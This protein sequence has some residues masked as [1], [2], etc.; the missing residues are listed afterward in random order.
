MNKCIYSFCEADNPVY[1]SDENNLNQFIVD[2]VNH[3]KKQPDFGEWL[4]CQLKGKSDQE[5][6]NYFSSNMF[7]SKI[8][9]DIP[10]GVK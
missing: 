2:F 6:I 1:F 4:Y 10:F 9:L 3:L 8:M 5:L 7:V